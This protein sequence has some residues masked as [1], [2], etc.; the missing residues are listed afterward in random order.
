MQVHEFIWELVRSCYPITDLLGR[1]EEEYNLHLL[2]GF[3]RTMSLVD[4]AP[5]KSASFYIP[6]MMYPVKRYKVMQTSSERLQH[7]LFFS[8]EK[9][10]ETSLVTKKSGKDG[11]D[12]RGLTTEGKIK[13]LGMLNPA[14]Q[15]EDICCLFLK[16]LES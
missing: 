5:K 1:D 2:T 15:R 11:Q 7:W 3:R 6:W 10:V 16:R 9:W 8:Q 13:Q 14:K 4:N 12:K